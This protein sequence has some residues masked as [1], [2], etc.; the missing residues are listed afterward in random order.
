MTTTIT[1]IERVEGKRKGFQYRVTVRC[2]F[3]RDSWDVV[4][5]IGP[6][7]LISYQ[8][9]Q[10]ALARHAGVMY[11]DSSYRMRGGA[12]QWAEDVQDLLGPPAREGAA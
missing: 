8:R 1:R 7:D 11:V 12:E 3:N 9:C 4:G 6:G 2:E 10:A 5:I